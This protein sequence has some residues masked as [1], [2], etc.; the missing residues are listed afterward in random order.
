[1]IDIFTHIQPKKYLETLEKKIIGRLPLSESPVTVTEQIPVITDIK[2]RLELMEQFPEMMQVLTMAGPPL[3]RIVNPEDA[4][5]LA[6]IANDEMAEIVARYPDRFAAAIA[7]LPFNNID[8]TLSEIDRTIKDLHFRGIEICTDINGRPLDSPELMPIYE[9]ME[10]Y[11]LPI[12]IHPAKERTI[13]DYEGEQGS[14][15]NLAS[16][17]GWPHATSMAMMRLACDG[18]LERYPKIKFVTHHA[19]GTIPYLAKR[20]SGNDRRNP[21]LPNT[22]TNYLRL[23]YYDTAV[24]G[25]ISG[26]MCAL[27]FCG[28]DHMVFGTDFPFGSEMGVKFIREAIR[29]IGEMDITDAERKG[30]F[31]GNAR[32]ILHL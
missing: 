29:S 13:P 11:D 28:A 32:R 24:L 7:C 17:L 25:N 23:F 22:I 18:V 3:E 4:I 30:I 27:D 19:G 1:M 14:K 5:E 21:K 26:L 16:T 31:E 2:S 12:F 9:K 15:Y 8:A 6:K 10:K 20:I